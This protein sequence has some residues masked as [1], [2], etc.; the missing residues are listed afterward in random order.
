MTITS[1]IEKQFY[2]IL[3]GK[4]IRPV[5]QPIVSL[6]D[7]EIMGYE[8]LSRIDLPDCSFNTEE[9][10]HVAE[11][12]KRVWELEALCRKKS[13]K[14]A[15]NKPRYAKLFINVDPNVIHDE[16]FKEGTTCKYLQKYGLN[17]SDIIFEI[18]ERTSIENEE[19]FK[20]TIQHYTRQNYQIAIDDFGSEYAGLNRICVLEPHFIKIDMAII[21]NI[22][23][24]NIKKSLVKSFAIFCQNANIKLIAEGIETREELATLIELGI[25]YGQGYYLKR[26]Q[27]TLCDLD[28]A[29]KQEILQL[30]L[31][32][33][34]SN[35]QTSFWSNVGHICHEQKITGPATPGY[36]IFEYI[37]SDSVI[38]EITVV[39]ENR[40]VLGVLTRRRLMEL[41][42][43]QYGY[44]LHAKKTASELMSKDFLMIDASTSIE[45]ASKL[46]MVRP[47]Q[48]LYD[49]VVVT[50]S[51]KYLGVV[52]VKDLLE[53]A[54]TIQVTRAVDSNPLSGLPGN[55]AIEE[56]VKQCIS[57]PT[58]YSI[59][60]LDLDNFKAYNDAYGFNSGDLM[61]KSVVRCMKNACSHQE[62]LGHIGG[63]DF[64]IIAKNHDLFAICLQITK[65][66]TDSIEHLYS[67]TD[68]GR[69]YIRSKNRNGFDDSFPIATLSIA[70]VTNRQ[71][72]FTTIDEFSKELVRLKKKAKQI[73]GH[74][75]QVV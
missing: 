54:V 3:A 60:Y 28:Q 61:I 16:K 57:L 13:L 10:F 52:S 70:I 20:K 9:M 24:D 71:N 45:M 2:D 23:S 34:A 62:F 35:Y 37:T 65:Q 15:V 46:S 36:A 47:Q 11:A 21:R 22:N 29:T 75:I 12:T 59:A 38:A 39:D 48:Q 55:T 1:T 5:Y 27:C 8:A 30:N 40:C 49:D 72:H 31:T 33:G 17:P 7:G 43:G 67:Q 56:A 73:P 64:V 44:S 18:T 25:D 19:T 41:F 50:E 14:H 69:G 74:S 58:P 26:P 51:G 68:W 66:F 42:G 6:V 53:T 63:D 32:H 4:K